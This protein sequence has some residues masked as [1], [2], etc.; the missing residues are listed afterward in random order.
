MAALQKEIW[1]EGLA[2]APPGILR[3]IDASAYQSWVFAAYSL[4]RASEQ[5]EVEGGHM[6]V[7]TANGNTKANPLLTII[8]QESAMMIR[9]AAEL[10]FTPVARARVRPGNG[11]D[12]AANPFAAFADAAAKAPK[13]N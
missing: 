11:G 5:F 4:R 8:R 12:K 7:V 3:E 1:R 2:S 9:C 6:V 10:G 13:P